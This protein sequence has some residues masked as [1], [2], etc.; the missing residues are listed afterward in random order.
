M[1]LR[2]VTEAKAKQK[3]GELMN[4]YVV[5]TKEEGKEWEPNGDGPV[6]K[7]TGSQTVL[8]LR[9]YCNCSAWLLPESMTPEH[10]KRLHTHI[11]RVF[12]PGREN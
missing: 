7:L 1:S 6:S 5:W 4:K 8:E 12:H 9:K 10:L 3:K 2:T 11:N